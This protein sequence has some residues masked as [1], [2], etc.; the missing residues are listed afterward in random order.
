MWMLTKSSK[1]CFALGAQVF[2]RHRPVGQSVGN[3]RNQGRELIEGSKLG[4]DGV[5]SYSAVAH[6]QGWLRW[7]ARTDKPTRGGV[8]I[9]RGSVKLAIAGRAKIFL[10]GPAGRISQ[11]RRQLTLLSPQKVRETSTTGRPPSTSANGEKA[12]RAPILTQTR[13]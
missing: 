3:V 11:R 10:Q 1:G 5:A 12:G 8:R 9:R 7:P 13:K 4:L 6:G 2:L